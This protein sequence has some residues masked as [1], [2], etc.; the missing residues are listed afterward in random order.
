[1]PTVISCGFLV[2]SVDDRFLLG[3][4]TG[5]PE[6]YCWSV[7]KGH[8]RKGE[9]YLETAIRELKEESGIDIL[10]D[11]MEKYISKDPIHSYSL[12]KK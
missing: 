9:T 3:R 7:F 2:K 10:K 1:M 8:S 6:P 5:H 12:K 4:A 11:N